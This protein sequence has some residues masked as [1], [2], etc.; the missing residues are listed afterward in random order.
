MIQGPRTLQ[1]GLQAMW[2]LARPLEFILPVLAFLLGVRLSSMYS[3]TTPQAVLVGSSALLAALISVNLLEGLGEPKRGPTR[4]SGRTR[5]EGL[6][7][8]ANPVGKKAPRMRVV[9]GYL[10]TISVFLGL[11]LLAQRGSF[12]AV[13]FFSYFAVPLFLYARH[14]VS[15]DDGAGMLFA[16]VLGWVALPTIAGLAL[17]GDF[18]VVVLPWVTVIAVSTFATL[19]GTRGIARGQVLAVAAGAIAALAI[20]LSYTPVLGLLHLEESAGACTISATPHGLGSV[21]PAL[22]LFV[23]A[24]LIARGGIRALGTFGARVVS[25]ALLCIALA[26]LVTLP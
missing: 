16:T 12:L 10:T 24:P 1:S 25:Q 5:A 20:V 23:L 2:S 17:V 22:A 6:F 13:M 18:P 21:A 9:L 14:R 7:F 8:P 26:L 15:A 4:T 19:A 11:T 3:S